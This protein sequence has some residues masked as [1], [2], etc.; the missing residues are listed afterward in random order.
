[1]Q[2]F[3]VSVAEIL[4]HPGAYRDVSVR[5]P[6]AGVET[7]LARLDDEPVEARLRLESVVEGVLVTGPVDASARFECARCLKPLEG[8]VS[9]D[10]CELFLAPGSQGPADED[11]YR[12]TGLELDLE[13]MLRDEVT[14][15]LP[16][17]P[18]CDQECKGLCAT[19]GKDLNAGS[20]DCVDEEMDPRWAALSDLRDKLA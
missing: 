1:V 2:G 18:V 16:L 11:A 3:K 7:A 10:V 6:L 5:S 17:K 15:A 19:C 12:V 8:G 4:G 20:C 9:L 13:P 14:L